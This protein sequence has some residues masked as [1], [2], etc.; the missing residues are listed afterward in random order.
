MLQ[1]VLAE[2]GR[3][4]ICRL[5]SAISSIIATS[6]FISLLDRLISQQVL[7]DALVIVA[8]RI[9]LLDLF[10]ICDVAARQGGIVELLR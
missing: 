4:C 1:G 10:Q 9:E 8:Q 3:R 5:T 2:G 7:F 6:G